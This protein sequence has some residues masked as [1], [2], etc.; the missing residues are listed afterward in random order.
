MMELK[1]NRELKELKELTEVERIRL[2]NNSSDLMYTSS[3][4]KT[5]IVQIKN[6]IIHINPVEISHIHDIDNPYKHK[7]FIIIDI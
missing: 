5:S 7:F 2:M 1:L 6:R 3:S 4:F